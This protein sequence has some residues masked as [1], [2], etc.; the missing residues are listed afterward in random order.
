M[1]TTPLNKE[2]FDALVIGAGPA[3]SSSA[4]ALA[5]G[6]FRVLLLERHPM[7]RPKLCGGA[8]SN[9]ALQ[10]LDFPI[11]P[12]MIDDVCKGARITYKDKVND[13]ALDR[14][15]STFIARDQFDAFLAEKAREAGAVLEIARVEELREE[16]DLILAST[17]AGA[18]RARFAVIACGAVSRLITKV[19]PLDAPGEMGFCLEHD[20][21]V[22]QPNPLSENKNRIALYFDQVEYGYGWAYQ[23]GRRYNVGIGGKW[24]PGQDPKAS[25]DAFCRRLGLPVEGIRYQGAMLP[26]GGVRRR[27]GRGRLLLA[28]D[29]AGFVD[30]FTGE[31]I[32][33]AIRSGQ[34]AAGAIREGLEDPALVAKD[35]VARN[36]ERRCWDEFGFKL[37]LTLWFSRLLY[38]HPHWAFPIFCGDEPLLREFLKTV[39]NQRSYVGYG[40]WAL[41][42]WT[43][44][45]LGFLGREVWGK[46]KIQKNQN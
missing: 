6:G 8:V 12:E 13:V 1:R 38:R 44:L 25:M 46:V 26:I 28:G 4:R 17:S 37:R 35:G 45:Y 36:Y 22:P 39:E 34:I 29:S 14:T 10:A 18:R 41:A 24:S 23:Q 42:R 40:L 2:I 33:Y 16:G 32:A 9:Q 30:P 31:G 27:V 20:F 3:G 15:V 5:L 43:R 7:P 11:P 19:R 21:P